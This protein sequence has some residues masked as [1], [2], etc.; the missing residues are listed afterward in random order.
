MNRSLHSG[1]DTH[2]Q[3]ALS[4]APIG[5]F[6]SD[7]E[8]NCFFV[9]KEWEKISGLSFAASQGKGWQ[10]IVLEED[11]PEI[12]TTIQKSEYPFVLNY[13]I[14]HPQK[15]LRYFRVDA[16]RVTD[17]SGHNSYITGYV[18]D[19]TEEKNAEGRQT[20]LTKHLQALITSLEDIVFE[21]DGNQTFRNVWVYDDSLL[22]MPRETFLGK[23]IQDVI[24]PQ[25]T[26]FS[27]VVA[28]VVKT[29]EVREIVYKHF[30]ESR[31]Q[32]FRAR[33]KPVIKAPDPA[34]YIMVL[35]IQDITAS[36]MAES[37]LQDI[38]SRLELAN[39]LLDV[40]QELS[41]TGGWELNLHTGEVFWTRHTYLIYDVA[42]DFVPSFDSMLSFY[43]EEY[44]PI[45]NSFREAAISQRKAYDIELRIITAKQVRK[46]IRVIGVPVI[47]DEEVVMIRGALMDITKRKED[48][49]ELIMA[50]NI[51]EDAARAKSD[52]LSIMSHEIRTPLNGI[53]GIAN[54]L[55]LNYMP[56]QEEYISNLLFSA[57]HL[58]QLINDILD[59]NK[60]EQDKLDLTHAEVSLSDLV[61]NIQNQ[62]KSLAS[63][64]GLELISQIDKEIPRRIIADPIR[65]GQILNNLVSNA[66]K[67][68]EKGT[69][70]ISLQQVSRLKDK[71][72]VHF[73]IKDTGIGIPKEHHETVFESFRQV[74][75]S[76]V[77]KQAGTGL[78][79]TITQK[80][81]TL[82]NSHIYIDSTPGVGTEFHFD[83]VFDLPTK[84]NKPPKRVQI[85]ELSPYIKKFKG[86]RLLFVEDNPI[87]IMVA[88]KQLEYFGILPD[89]AQCGEDALELLKENTY[90]VAFVDLHMPEM[91]GYT[92][93]QIIRNQY[94]EIH[95]VIFTADIMPEVRRKFARMGIFDILN[96]PF[97]PR[98]MLSTL[99]KIAQIKK[100]DI[101]V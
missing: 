41:Q 74:Q 8:G 2:L 72:T 42:P 79:L 35:S 5:A 55:K 50:K 44:R 80:L 32:W 93:S 56:D 94:S 58:L 95:I 76:A 101:G 15:G 67:Y 49:L 36:R 4:F 38:K 75:Q 96:K 9:N 27:N 23:K 16:I 85:T 19:T 34:D 84:K 24:G 63:A 11:L 100:M 70:T 20:E 53:I 30:E 81:I 39:Q 14:V 26:A 31:N 88:E 82:H 65:L 46:W 99:L 40:S 47:K 7:M 73:S 3:Q 52:F 12:I 13:R 83:L 89:C 37:S 62:F 45:I 66:I 1:E 6:L 64:K 90:D 48:E 29:G 18:Q 98:E 59:L 54:L 25:A 43:E 60:M 77:R 28:E 33:I 10:K 87:N 71:T 17:G 78:G 92:L 22:Y 68:T 21:I 61:K 57:D 69:V 86:I 91:D 51:A 97:F